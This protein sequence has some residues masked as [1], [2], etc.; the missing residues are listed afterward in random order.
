MFQTWGPILIMVV[1]FYFLLY[2]PQKAEQKR[3][4][5][6]LD[7][8]KS[9]DRVVTIGGIYGTLGEIGEKSVML[10]VSDRVEI[11]VARAAINGNI[12]QEESNE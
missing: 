5:A 10:K 7:N 11:E 1:I 4:K 8:L 3:R 6:M 12:S 9:G 2:R